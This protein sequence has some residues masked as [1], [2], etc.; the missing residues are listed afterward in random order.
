MQ[1]ERVTAQNATSNDDVRLMHRQTYETF[2]HYNNLRPQGQAVEVVQSTMFPSNS[3]SSE[4][5]TAKSLPSYKCSGGGATMGK[6]V[7][8]SSHQIQAAASAD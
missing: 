5:Q 1:V 7:S 4:P 8:M 3:R 6:T 2:A